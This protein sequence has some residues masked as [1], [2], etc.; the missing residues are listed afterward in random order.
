M[1][2]STIPIKERLDEDLLPAEIKWIKTIFPEY[3]VDHEIDPTNRSL[4]PP[5]VTGLIEMMIPKFPDWGELDAVSTMWE[6][7]A[8][9]SLRSTCRSMKKDNCKSLLGQM[10]K[11]RAERNAA[12]VNAADNI[13][14][15]EENKSQIGDRTRNRIGKRSAG[16]ILDPPSD[17]QTSTKQDDPVADKEQSNSSNLI[18]NLQI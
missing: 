8:M 7:D 12:M 2:K 9:D 3:L 5:L 11:I 18:K 6:R 17:Q 10:E 14:E 4:D 13:I 16:K 15:Q 1:S